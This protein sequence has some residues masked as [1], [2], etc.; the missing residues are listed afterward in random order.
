MSDFDAR[1]YGA[2]GIAE[3]YDA[4]Y[5]DHWETDAAVVC[6]VEL[7]DV[8]PRARARHRHRPAGPPD[9]VRRGL[10]VHGIDGS[11]E[12][13]AKLR[14]KAGGEQLHR[15]RHVAWFVQVRHTRLDGSDWR[16]PETVVAQK[17][18]CWAEVRPYTGP[19]YHE[20][21]SSPPW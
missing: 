5:A 12:M 19:G 10:D 9:M 3:D 13:V 20:H 4:L 14:E 17:H 18:S 1:E 7:T 21:V 2:S 15:A 8:G 6:L 16:P 11:P